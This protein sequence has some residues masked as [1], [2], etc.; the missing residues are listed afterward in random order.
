MGNIGTRAEL[1]NTDLYG[2]IDWLPA[3]LTGG[4]WLAGGYGEQIRLV[5]R[6]SVE[7]QST[8]N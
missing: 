7:G 8:L 6:A 3:D 5:Y 4:P 2:A 1:G